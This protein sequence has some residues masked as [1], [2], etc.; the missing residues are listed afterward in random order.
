MDECREFHTIADKEDRRVVHHNVEV[1]LGRVE[2][3]GEAAG[4]AESVRTALFATHG[5]EADCD[6]GFLPYFT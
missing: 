4:V 5:T 1:T 2:F 6:G 3:Y